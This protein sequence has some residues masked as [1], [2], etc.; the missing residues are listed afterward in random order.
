MKR[1][2]SFLLRVMVPALM[3]M[4]MITVLALR[5]AY[6]QTDAPVPPSID[7]LVEAI[8]SAGGTYLIAYLVNLARVKWGIV[9]GSVFVGIL[10]PVIGFG[11]SYLMNL[12]SGGSNSWLVSFVA[13]LGSVWLSQ[14]QAQL[15]AKTGAV[16]YK[17]GAPQ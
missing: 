10:V 8:M 15:N 14:L 6:A 11:V 17:L 3:L 9:T 7:Q 5:I 12:L 13:T 4:L 16:Q 1:F 2:V